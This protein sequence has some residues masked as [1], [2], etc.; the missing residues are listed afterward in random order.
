MPVAPIVH[1]DRCRLSACR[2]GDWCFF[3]FFLSLR[4][5]LRLT[6]T[7]TTGC[8][9]QMM[10]WA[11]LSKVHTSASLKYPTGPKK[12]GT[13]EICNA[14]RSPPTMLTDRRTYAD[15]RRPSPYD[16]RHRHVS[17]V[18]PFVTSHTLVA[19]PLPDQFPQRR[20]PNHPSRR[21]ARYSIG[22]AHATRHSARA[23]LDL[24]GRREQRLYPS[25]PVGGRPRTPQRRRR[26]PRCSLRWKGGDEPSVA[27][28]C[29]RRVGQAPPRRCRSARRGRA[30]LPSPS[31][32]CSVRLCRTIV[33]WPCGKWRRRKHKR[34]TPEGCLR[35]SAA[36]LAR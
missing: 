3:F 4:T 33:M 26:P 9:M 21:Q 29:R 16:R 10:H 8:D 30:P 25:L 18:V 35:C 20:D 2:Y 28:C 19:I 36:A 24:A 31:R 11:L 22:T 12:K 14:C 6:T 17:A 1:G 27:A 34:T 23:E 7:T 5:I 13:T 32:C 15:D